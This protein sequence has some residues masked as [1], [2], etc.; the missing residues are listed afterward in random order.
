MPPPAINRFAFSTRLVRIDLIC[1]FIYLCACLCYGFRSSFFSLFAF[2]FSFNFF[3][4]LF[5]YSL[6][7]FVKYMYILNSKNCT[8]VDPVSL[9]AGNVTL[10]IT[11]GCM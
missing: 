6:F 3:S 2:C 10:A 7:R 4:L 5:Q 9:T 1:L 11:Y 8:R